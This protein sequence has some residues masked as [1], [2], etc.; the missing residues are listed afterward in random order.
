MS[1]FPIPPWIS[2]IGIGNGMMS[3]SIAVILGYFM[4]ISQ[5][6]D[7][8]LILIEEININQV[9]L[10]P[11]INIVPSRSYRRSKVSAYV[12]LPITLRA[13]FSIACPEK[14]TLKLIS[15]YSFWAITLELS[16][17]VLETNTK[18]CIG[19]I[20]DLGLL[21]IFRAFSWPK[22]ENHPMQIFIWDRSHIK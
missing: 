16:G 6:S 2:K 10:V 19:W 15:A 18:I 7:F 13:R 14:R 8:W 11:W 12:S 9:L 4:E 17:Y 21:E 20:F 22:S 5:K 3:Y 1:I